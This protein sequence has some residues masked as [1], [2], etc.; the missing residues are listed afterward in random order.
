MYVVIN[1][2]MHLLIMVVVAPKY[3]IYELYYMVFNIS[4]KIETNLN[5]YINYNKKLEKISA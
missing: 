4:K 1:L 3:L 2:T 5:K